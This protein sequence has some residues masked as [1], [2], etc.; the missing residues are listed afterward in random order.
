MVKNLIWW[1]N[2]NKTRKRGEKEHNFINVVRQMKNMTLLL[3][4]L[5]KILQLQ[6][7]VVCKLIHYREYLLQIAAI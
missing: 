6:D 7:I 3:D 1:I 5:Y 4:Y 2:S